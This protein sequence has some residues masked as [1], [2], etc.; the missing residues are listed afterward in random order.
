M[1]NSLIHEPMSDLDIK[2]YFPNAKII[3]YNEL[4]KYNHINEILPNN[5][6]YA[7]L[8]Y[9]TDGP[10]SGHWV[11]ISKN[12]NAIEIFDSYGMKN[13]D[14]ELL[15]ITKEERRALKTNKPHLTRL[16]NDCNDKVIFNGYRYQL[17]QNDSQTC[18]RHCVN[19]LNCIMNNLCLM[20]Y[21]K[22]MKNIK[23]HTG[24]DYDEIVSQI[25]K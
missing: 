24:L 16:L 5:K 23:N 22:F 8:L 11:L 9:L 4:A 10:A 20:K 18:G 1:D 12:N 15:W 3:K 17:L 6:S 2:K 7:F 14:D 13:P 19:R 25:I 21:Y